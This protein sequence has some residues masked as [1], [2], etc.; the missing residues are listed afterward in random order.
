M[1]DDATMH[2]ERGPLKD[3]I[4]GFDDSDGVGYAR[5]GGVLT[6][7][8]ATEFVAS[9]ATVG[10]WSGDDAGKSLRQFTSSGGSKGVV[11]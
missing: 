7:V 11:A 8:A 9:A 4:E 6:G 10:D 1:S 5:T 3:A 2:P